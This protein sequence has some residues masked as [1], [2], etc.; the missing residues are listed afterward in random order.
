MLTKRGFDSRYVGIRRCPEGHN[1]AT[2][3]TA[4]GSDARRE[5]DCLTVC[6]IY[7]WLL[8]ALLRH[9]RAAR[10]TPGEEHAE[11]Q[12]ND[13]E[14]PRVTHVGFTIGLTLCIS[15]GPPGATLAC[16]SIRRS[17]LASRN[18]TGP[19]RWLCSQ[20]RDR[21]GPPAACACYAADLLAPYPVHGSAP[22]VHHC[23][24]ANIRRRDCV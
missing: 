14:G 24:Y 13:V 1:L 15:C 18:Q 4:N 12:R 5:Y 17:F 2:A 3:I 19:L 6:D 21:L 8:F 11:R 9:Q 7:Q 16:I 20:G 23:K 10:S 22:K